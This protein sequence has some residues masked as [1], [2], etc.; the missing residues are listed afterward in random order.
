VKTA[1][2]SPVA[3][4]EHEFEAAHGLPEP[5]PA[6]EKILWQGAP[7]WHVLAREAFHVR[8]VGGWLSLMLCLRAGFAW[9]DTGSMLDVLVAVLWL[10]PLFA[11]A[12][13]VLLVLAWLSARTTAY[14]LTDRRIIMRVGI[15][16]SL[17][18]N[19]PLRRLASAGLRVGAAGVGDIPLQLVAG[20]KIAYVHLW[21]HARPWRAAR[22][23]PMLRCVPQALAVARQLGDAWSAATG[24]PAHPPLRVVPAPAAADAAGAALAA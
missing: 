19:L 13:G 14:T 18:F 11:F 24:V 16:L 8:L 17:T 3:A 21:P 2:R 4:A 1:L 22:P 7:D 9:L 15:V 6:G 23:E 10:A 12:V 20:E 5:L